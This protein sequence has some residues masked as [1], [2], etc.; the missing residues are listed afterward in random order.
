[1]ESELIKTTLSLAAV[2]Y[3]A[4]TGIFKARETILAQHQRMKNVKIE[5]GDI[6][7][8]YNIIVKWFNRLMSFLLYIL[9]IISIYFLFSNICGL[10]S[11]DKT[12]TQHSLLSSLLEYQIYISLVLLLI[13]FELQEK[14]ISNLLLKILKLI[15]RVRNSVGWIC[16]ENFI[17]VH[18]FNWMGVFDDE[19][20]NTIGSDIQK[21]LLEEGK[22]QQ[23]HSAYFELYFQA[24]T[25]DKQKLPIIEIANYVFIGVVFE[26]FSRLYQGA[27]RAQYQLFWKELAKVAYADKKPFSI[28]FIKTCVIE[29]KDYIEELINLGA[30]MPNDVAIRDGVNNEI[31]RLV[32]KYDGNAYQLAF[33][34][35]FNK[36]SK[37]LLFVR[38]RRFKEISRSSKNQRITQLFV[39]IAARNEI[40]KKLYLKDIQ[41]PFNAGIA[42]FILNTR[43]LK[44][45]DHVT[46]I[47]IDKSF[48]VLVKSTL[49]RIVKSFSDL[50]HSPYIKIPEKDVIEFIFG[51]KLIDI[52]D[53]HIFDLIDL[54][55]YNHAKRFCL[56]ASKSDNIN[57]VT[58]E[59][60]IKKITGDK[61]YCELLIIKPWGIS[62][63][64]DFME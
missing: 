26:S 1:M 45:L 51:R 15:P 4:I 52:K 34:P 64:G 2:V 47:K 11:V 14:L 46:R 59:C 23:R 53:Y 57:D 48:E 30:N 16:A 6:G 44:I 27:K 38:L 28:N 8:P 31:N 49:N 40:W 37:M 12:P 17:N 50:I 3:S 39:K 35:F 62:L 20:I 60:P 25:L 33:I 63:S 41:Y 55:I 7:F 43:C 42:A 54:W 56:E 22:T 19:K 32:K 9:F 10:I 61:C 5:L 21:I 29:K 13:N 24:P 18:N 36:V 58:T